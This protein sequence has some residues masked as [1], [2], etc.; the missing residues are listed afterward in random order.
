MAIETFTGDYAKATNA[1]GDTY[2]IGPD[3]NY[4]AGAAQA[5]APDV[6]NGSAAADWLQGAGGND[7]LAGGAGD[8][9]VEGGAGSD[10]LLGGW[11]ADTINGGA[12]NDPIF[13]SYPVPNAVSPRFGLGPQANIR[14]TM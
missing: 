14:S 2:L 10:L 7:G 8:D 13:L 12:G 6:L 11:G 3:G 5:D 9:L 4:L 1:E